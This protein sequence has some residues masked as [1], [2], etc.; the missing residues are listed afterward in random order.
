[1]VLSGS[2]ID[3]FRGFLFAQQGIDASQTTAKEGVYVE[4][5]AFNLPTGLSNETYQ[6]SGGA[7]GKI[8]NL[9]Y[10][11]MPTKF[12]L[13]QSGDTFLDA[14]TKVQQ[15]GVW[16]QQYTL[17]VE[18]TDYDE[19]YEEEIEEEEE[20]GGIG[21]EEED[22][23]EDDEGD[24][25]EDDGEGD[26][27]ILGDIE[28]YTVDQL[29]AIRNDLEGSY[30]LMADID[31]TG[32]NWEPIGTSDEPFTGIFDGN[33]F[34]IRNLQI[35][36]PDQ[37][38]AGLF[39]YNEGLLESVLLENVTVAGRDYTGG[40]VGYNAGEILNCSVSGTLVTGGN[41][42]GGL[43]GY[44]SGSNAMVKESSA[45]INV[46]GSDYVG[47]FVGYAESGLLEQCNAF[48]NVTATGFAGAFEGQTG[49]AVLTNCTGTGTVTILAPTPTPTPTPAPSEGGVTIEI[50][51]DNTT[52]RVNGANVTLD[53]PATILNGRTVVPMRFVAEN[54]GAIVDWDELARMVTVTKGGGN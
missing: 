10:T 21:E 44:N 45:A 46:Q 3:V 40:L 9:M 18:D 13:V 53:Q 19:D 51:I 49:T 23:D 35:N 20:D 36:R 24:E 7:L 43:V 12:G 41:Y 28:I 5:S 54:M 22:E 8:N 34:V 16:T 39:G 27:I 6:P 47:G 15:G 50:F 48:G 11:E 17:G 30:Y 38:Y 32:I 52:A 31:L 14:I 42:V 25:D 2:D 29:N 26:E 37:D 1:M 4:G 33:G